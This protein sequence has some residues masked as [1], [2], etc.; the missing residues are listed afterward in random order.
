MKLTDFYRR[1]LP[2][3]G[4]YCLFGPRMQHLWYDT[5]EELEAGTEKYAH[6]EAGWYFGTNGFDDAKSRKQ[7]NVVAARSLRLDLDCGAEK[8]AKHG[9]EKCYNDQ[10]E[11][12]AHIAQFFQWSGLKPTI[13]VD[14]GSGIHVYY[15]FDEDFPSMPVWQNCAEKLKRLTRAFGLKADP[16]VTADSAR[17]LRPVGA[18]HKNG[19]TVSA[20]EVRKD[21]MTLAEFAGAFR[22]LEPSLPVDAQAPTTPKKPSGINADVFDAPRTD[23]KSSVVKAAGKC[24]WIKNSLDAK[25]DVG[26]TDWLNMLALFKVSVEG[27]DGAVDWSS[28]ADSFDED[29][30]RTKLD[31]LTGGAPTCSKI[32]DDNPACRSC[33]QWGKIKTPYRLGMLND[34]EIASAAAPQEKVEAFTPFSDADLGEDDA[35]LSDQTDAASAVEADDQVSKAF[36][37]AAKADQRDSLV[38]EGKLPEDW[39]T[40]ESMKAHSDVNPFF[41]HRSK[42]GRVLLCCFRQ[43]KVKVEGG[44]VTVYKPLILTEQP[45][46]IAGFVNGVSGGAQVILKYIH[47]YSIHKMPVWAHTEV[48]SKLLYDE[49]GFRDTVTDLGITPHNAADQRESFIMMQRYAAANLAL[50]RQRANSDHFQHRMGFQFKQEKPV[51]VQGAYIA[52]DSGDIKPCVLGGWLRAAQ[53]GYELPYLPSNDPAA[54]KRDVFSEVIL[55]KA[56]QYVQGISA[57]YNKPDD[58]NNDPYA[59]GWFLGV[60]SP[61]M[62]FVTSELPTP[63]MDLPAM[64]FTLSL[65]SQGSGFGKSAVQRCIMRAF[66]DPDL[67]RAGGD[68]GSGGSATSIGV[69]LATRGS[70]PYFIDEVSNNTPEQV[71][72]LIHKINIGRDKVRLQRDGK[73]VDRTGSWCSI[74]NMSSNVSQRMLLTEHRR[75]SAA[76]QM[77]VIEVDFERV[78]K[79]QLDKA[80]FD[81]VYSRVIAPA[82]GALGMLLGRHGVTHWDALRARAEEL[83]LEITAQFKLTQEERYY[84]ALY[85]AAKLTAEVM[86]SYGLEAVDVKLMDKLFADT[87]ADTRTYIV[88]TM[89]TNSDYAAQMVRDLMPRILRTPTETDRRGNKDAQ[90]D[91]VSN[92][93]I[94][95]RSR[96]AGRYVAATHRLYLF[97]NDV[98]DWM[99]KAGGLSLR[100]LLR[101]WEMTGFLTLVDGQQL[102]QHSIDKGIHPSKASNLKG[103]VYTFNTAHLGQMFEGEEAP[104][105]VVQFGTAKA[106]A[107][108]APHNTETG[109]GD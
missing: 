1:V 8:V 45:F 52:D 98:R 41:V 21:D 62:A 11:A 19:R 103:R 58:R 108:A 97:Q 56:K 104:Q 35:S 100:N 22:A 29:L 59:L 73:P 105:N 107:A 102:S 85:A 16:A 86:A 46:Q 87:I 7:E 64:G 70:L 76:E 82:S 109:T 10:R 66:G 65:Y 93:E 68:R 49:K 47:Q 24:I 2:A 5:I 15:T 39:P 25:G 51:Y 101:E 14:S 81:T 37:E 89:P 90:Y 33:A 9:I 50:L 99:V 54:F 91:E 32:S 6:A 17:V 44:S 38:A 31:T 72:E 40:L 63:G 106:E 30:T 55:P 61:Y 26:Y 84:A 23:T 95:N 83:K 69:Q 88:E 78:D 74:A 80:T 57:V 79:S 42:G 77:R 28:G 13:V 20:K 4:R 92:W 96:I 71:S 27:E 3:S 36:A 34:V 48:S 60:A 12:L 67:N 18:L 53:P 75:H 43:V 94:V